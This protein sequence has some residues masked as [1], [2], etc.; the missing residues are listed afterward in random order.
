VGCHDGVVAR[1]VFRDL[2]GNGVQSKGGSENIEIT[3]NRFFSAGERAVNIGG[4][5]GFE[6]FRP[7]LS[8]SEVNAEARDIRV[9]ANVFRGGVSPIA[10]VGCVG[11]LVANNTIV[12]PEHWVVRIL[13]ETT[14]EG[15]YEFAPASDGRFVNNIVYYALA[16][17]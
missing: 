12:E 14:S 9:D 11:C 16:D 15:E 3:Q 6:F 2:G 1:N 10:F 7:A 4:S 5:T 13:Q 17:L 8:T